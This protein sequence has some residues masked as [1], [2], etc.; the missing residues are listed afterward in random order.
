MAKVDQNVETAKN[1]IELDE[2]FQNDRNE[3]KDYEDLRSIGATETCWRTFM[4]ETNQLC[5]NVQALS[6]HLENGQ[7]VP[8]PRRRRNISD[9][10]WPARDNINNVVPLQP[11]NSR[12][13][14]TPSVLSRFSAR[15]R[16]ERIV[17][18]VDQTQEKPNIQ[19]NWTSL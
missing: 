14:R 19:D 12:S 10:S 5:P 9:R 2:N 11:P 16:L 4:F 6:I 18:N 13:V 7:R 3:I 1:E 15:P 8:F 17:K